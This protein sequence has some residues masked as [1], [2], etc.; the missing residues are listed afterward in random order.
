MYYATI[1]PARIEIASN[2]NT[3]RFHE[4]GVFSWAVV[5]NVVSSAECCYTTLR[6]FHIPNL[7]INVETELFSSLFMSSRNKKKN[8]ERLNFISLLQIVESR[9]IRTLGFLSRTQI[10]TF[11]RNQVFP[12]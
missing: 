8:R 4:R 6:I 1:V 3:R 5:E 2:K 9:T 7:R 10:K 11:K 12:G